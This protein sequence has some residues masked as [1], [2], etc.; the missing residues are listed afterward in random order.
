MEAGP[1]RAAPSTPRGGRIPYL[2]IH[3]EL[4]GSERD[5]PDDAVGGGQ[6]PLGVDEGAPAVVH[7]GGPVII[8]DFQADLPR[9]LPLGGIVAPDDA[10]QLVSRE[11][12]WEAT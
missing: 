11:G 4:D 6:H 3:P 5:S 7:P 2:L 8:V 9:P 12:G 1:S 10:H